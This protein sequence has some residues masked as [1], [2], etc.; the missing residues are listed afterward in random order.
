MIE[1]TEPGLG[2][3][4]TDTKPK[5]AGGRPPK[6]TSEQ[7]QEVYESLQSYILSN[8]DPTIVGFVS[9]NDTAIQYN[10][11]DSNLYD[12]PEFSGLIKRA[13]KKQEAYLLDG[14]TKNKLNATMAIF[15]LKQPQHGYKDRT[16]TDVTTN[17]K[18]IG[19]QFTPEQAEQLLRLRAKRADSNK[20]SS[21]V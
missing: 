10:L 11:N 2:Q 16:E 3:P 6:L 17:G 4:V 18:D 1:R 12:W 15:R 8:D 5:H 13:I 14:A 9:V 7:K 19:P 20:W 21:R